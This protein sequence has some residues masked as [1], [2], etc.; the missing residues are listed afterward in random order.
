MRKLKIPGRTHDL[1]KTLHTYLG[2]FNFTHLIVFGIAGLVATLSP[3]PEDRQPASVSVQEVSFN[4]PPGLSDKEIADAVYTELGLPLTGPIPEWAIR[5]NED[6]NLLL[7]FYT[8]NGPY[9][10]TVFEDLERLR[11]VREKNGFWQFVSNLHSTL[12]VHDRSGDWR[13][14]AWTW[15][16]EIALWSFLLMAVSGLYLWVSSRPGYLPS[17][18]A[19]LCGGSIF[20]LLYFITR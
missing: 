5:R 6:N 20:L 1:I 4:I 12:R 13:L 10:V 15:Y 2:L 18:V 14:V 17:L 7:N 16:I 11:I 19:I 8:A 9:R 3:P